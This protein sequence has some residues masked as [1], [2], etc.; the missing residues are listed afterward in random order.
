MA[1][2]RFYGHSDDIVYVKGASSAFDTLTNSDVTKNGEFSVLIDGYEYAEFLVNDRMHVRA[3]YDGC[4]CFAP[5]LRDEDDECPL[6]E[7][8]NVRVYRSGESPNS[9]E[10]HLDV[11][12]V[13]VGVQRIQ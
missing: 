6:G 4:W 12:E 13:H 3:F 11:P 7:K 9:M 2:L 1:T 8:W 5:A 10:L